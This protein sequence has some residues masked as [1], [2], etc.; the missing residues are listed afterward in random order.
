[1]SSAK[2]RPKRVRV[3]LTLL[4]VAA[5][6]VS[7]S[8]TTAF[9]ASSSDQRSNIAG[10][11]AAW[12]ARAHA[13]GA[14]SASAKISF[15]VL[16]SLRDAAGAARVAADVSNPKSANYG[17]YLSAKQFN[18]RYAPT[19]AQV[20]SVRSYL[21]GE[22]FK[23]SGV[24]A[25]NRWLSAT[26]TVRQVESAFGT[27]LRTYSYEGQTLR[28]A[29]TTL[30]V[31]AKI[32]GLVMGFT[33]VSQASSLHKST[34][35]RP[36]QAAASTPADAQP[37]RAACSTF[38]DQN[39]QTVPLVYGK[40][41]LPT[42]NC[43]YSPAQLRT[44][45]G[46]Q[47]AV[48]HG[49]TGRGVTV[50]IIDAYA[51]PTMLSD[52]NANATLQGEPVFAA[53]QYTETLFGPQDLQDE[54]GPVGWNEEESLDVEAV[55][56]LAPGANVHYFGA[57]DCDTGIDTAINYVVQN[58]SVDIVSNSYG[59]TGEDGL[60]SEVA[61]EHSLF[62]QAAAEGIGFYFSTGDDGD[63]V[64][65]DGLSH[66]EPDYSATDPYVTAVGGTSLAVKSSNDY[67]FETSWGDDLA[68]V[69]FATSP[70]SYVTPPPGAFLFGGGGGVSSL[71]T[72]PAYQKLA[73]PS[74]LA[75]LNGP[76]AM[77]VVP[78]ISAV[79]DPETGFLIT[80][81]GGTGTI[82]G[83]SL[84]CP[85]IA[86]IQALASQGR[87]FPI[88]F[89]NPLLYVLSLTGVAF[90]DVQAPAQ[91]IAMATQSGR[92]L[93]TMGQDSSLTATKRYDDSTGLGTPYGPVLL[94][95]EKLLP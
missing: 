70:S 7:L 16:L 3:T 57:A 60:G 21:V 74:S 56:G 13:V 58:H 73:V 87:R 53:G 43:G 24:A 76:T 68:S 29:A 91:P 62:T 18:Q 52:A 93:L 83:T 30:S 84:A 27:T 45:Y 32:A 63:N 38:W 77:R 44:A 59:Y 79:A 33:G 22:G 11:D 61:L 25:G 39:E 78:D 55:H 5:M 75:K 64:E 12:T 8:A 67:L 80:F 31:P 90:H 65:L 34:A 36:S 2:A 40:T 47:S 10:S 69:N 46:V 1:M 35:V 72:E 28:G 95:G 6:T 85:V 86:G 82:G 92:S 66:P 19:A 26:G 54:C 4:T 71:F 49:D 42:N 81:Q 14:P 37:P 89:A 51:S 17:K 94:L 9:A 88:G 23:V 48:T 15:N 50:G 20:A 41:S